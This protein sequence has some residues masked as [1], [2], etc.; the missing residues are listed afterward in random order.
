M[1]MQG[2][3][4]N[5][6]RGRRPTAF[7]DRGWG[8]MENCGIRSRQLVGSVLMEGGQTFMATWRTEE[9]RA[10]EVHRNQ[11][12]PEETDKT[13]IAPGVTAG[14]LRRFTVLFL[15]LKYGGGVPE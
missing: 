9:E 12:E 14:Q 2:E 6:L 13:P 4:V 7:R 3:R 5:G 1:G 11:R 10:A 15:S 8:G